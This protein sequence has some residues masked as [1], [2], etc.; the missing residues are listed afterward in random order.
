MWW[1]LVDDLVLELS[2]AMAAAF[3]VLSAFLLVRFRTHSKDLAASSD[4]GRSL[5]SALETRLKKQDERILDVMARMEVLQ[6]RVSQPRPLVDAPPPKPIDPSMS[7]A[8]GMFQPS[9]GRGERI[10]ASRSLEPTEK[11]VLQLLSQRPH[12]SVEI[13]ALISKSREHTARLMKNLFERGLVVRNDAK[14]P[15]LY[16][17]TEQGRRYFSEA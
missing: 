11:V 10:I 14:K 13:K 12:T 4:I 8:I 1:V 9:I 3:L 2:V 5:F 17:I 7:E 6:S 15:F 16:Q